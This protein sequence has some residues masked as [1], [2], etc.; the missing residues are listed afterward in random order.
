MTSTVM[1][2]SKRFKLVI[3]SIDSRQDIIQ[4]LETL[5]GVIRLY[6]TKT[7]GPVYDSNMQE[8]GHWE[9]KAND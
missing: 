6:P 8:V 2:T 3:E 9:I 4:M 7:F 5:T 1:A